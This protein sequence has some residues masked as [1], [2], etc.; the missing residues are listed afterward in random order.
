[1]TTGRTRFSAVRLLVEVVLIVL[2]VFLGLFVNE[3]RIEQRDRS[4]TQGALERIKTELQANQ[5]R[6][7]RISD[8][9]VAVRDSLHMFLSQPD[10]LENPPSLQELWPAMSGGFGVPEVQDHAWTLANRQGALEHMDITTATILS[11]TYSLQEFYTDK[12]ERLSDNFY[13]AANI[14]PGSRAGL[15]IA[16]ALLANDIVNHEEDLTEGYAQALEIL[17]PVN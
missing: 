2:G 15:V 13:I 10:F 9:H 7:T 5:G 6:I 1:M 12:Y 4:R 16:L 8:H 14:G 17:E 11:Q 3:M